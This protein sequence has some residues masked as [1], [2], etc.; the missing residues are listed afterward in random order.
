MS[1][2]ERWP[3][4]AG[5]KAQVA[6]EKSDPDYRFASSHHCGAAGRAGNGRLIGCSAMGDARRIAKGSA[7]GSS[8][9]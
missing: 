9:A 4:D 8:H 2:G 5:F 6:L 7:N 1:K 3:R